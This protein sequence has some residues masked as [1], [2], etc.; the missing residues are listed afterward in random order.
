MPNG[1]GMLLLLLMATMKTMVM[2]VLMVVFPEWCRFH[3]NAQ[4]ST[5]H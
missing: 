1:Y 3:K 2:M 5:P 4:V